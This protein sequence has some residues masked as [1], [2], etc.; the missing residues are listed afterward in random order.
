MEE[1]KSNNHPN[2]KDEKETHLLLVLSKHWVLTNS[3]LRIFISVNDKFLNIYTS[4]LSD[5]HFSLNVK[6]LENGKIWIC[7]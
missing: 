4:I 1:A 7:K 5:F 2:K 6:M 3:I